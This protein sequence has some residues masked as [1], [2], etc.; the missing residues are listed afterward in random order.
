KPTIAFDYR[1]DPDEPIGVANVFEIRD[2]N[3][4]LAGELI[5]RTPTDQAAR[6]MDLGPAGV[7]YELSIHFDPRSV[8]L[9]Y[10]PEGAT[11]TV[12]GSPVNGPITIVRKWELLRVAFCLTGIDGGTS[13]MFEADTEQFPVNWK[14]SSKT[15]FE[16]MFVSADK[17]IS[18]GNLAAEQSRDRFHGNAPPS[19]KFEAMFKRGN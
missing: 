11:T 18:G 14:E 1:H 5:S 13:A 19:G 17:P 9:E 4:Y 2:G 12:N 8:V 10:L 3:L 15:T 6:I 7:P 16:R